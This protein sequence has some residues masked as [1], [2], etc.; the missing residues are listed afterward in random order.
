[1]W[2]SESYDSPVIE[3]KK[4]QKEN[5][6]LKEQLKEIRKMIGTISSV[7]LSLDKNNENK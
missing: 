2:I 1:M 5:E 4:L 3:V 7:N 6:E